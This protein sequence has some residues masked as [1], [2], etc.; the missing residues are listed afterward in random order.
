VKSES[1]Q[2]K[3]VVEKSTKSLPAVDTE[4]SLGAA[5]TA[6]ASSSPTMAP[7]VATPVLSTSKLKPK[8]KSEQPPGIVTKI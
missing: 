1:T 7:N 8:I 3:E 4:D 6:S 5:I 2:L